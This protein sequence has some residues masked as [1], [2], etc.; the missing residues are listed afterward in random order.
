MSSSPTSDF[1][2]IEEI[3]ADVTQRVGDESTRKISEGSYKRFVK[4]ALNELNF[5]T[6]FDERYEDILLP[7]NLRLFIPSGCWNIIDIFVWNG[8]I[9][10][11]ETI[12][13]DIYDNTTTPPTL[14]NTIV[15]TE[16]VMVDCCTITSSERVYHKNQFRTNGKGTGY[17]APNKPGQRDH[18]YHGCTHNW[19]TFDSYLHF[20]SVQGGVIMFSDTCQA[21]KYARIIYNGTASDIAKSKIVPRVVREAVILYATCEAFAVLKQR[22]KAF[23]IDW[24]DTRQELYGQRDKHTSSVWEQAVFLLKLP[25]T[26]VRSDTN[27]FLS[28]GNW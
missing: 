15:T 16:N 21:Y 25:D 20:F 19:Y 4:K 6:R 14:I 2:S 13:E 10:K 28:R 24:S 1:I 11:T 7:S 9:N 22:D 23:R 12:T 3:L 18:F 26:K 8:T 5:E 17:T 27:E